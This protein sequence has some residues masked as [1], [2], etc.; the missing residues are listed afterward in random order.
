M[1]HLLPQFW[2]ARLSRCNN[3]GNLPG[4]CQSKCKKTFDCDN[5]PAA[6]TSHQFGRYWKFTAATSYTAAKDACEND[7]AQLA[8]IHNW[9]EYEHIDKSW[10]CKDTYVQ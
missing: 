8:V 10:K 4:L 6:W 2:S 5:P 1:L 9:Y 7:G 3:W